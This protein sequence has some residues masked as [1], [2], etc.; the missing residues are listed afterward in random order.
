MPDDTA[1]PTAPCTV[2]DGAM[3]ALRALLRDASGLEIEDGRLDCAFLELGLDS[4]F[5]TQF[6]GRVADRFGVEVSFRRLATDLGSLRSLAAWIDAARGPSAPPEPSAPGPAPLAA[7]RIDGAL[8]EVLRGQLD[9]MRRQLKLIASPAA[10]LPT[11]PRQAAASAAPPAVP[12]AAAPSAP[13]TAQPAALDAAAP[14]VGGA[15][16]GR[17]ADGAPAWFV[18][19][20]TRP[21]RYRR[22]DA[23]SSLQPEATR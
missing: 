7:L 11:A 16:L 20:P 2:R 19:D 3:P 5:L 13:P 4:L 15:R 8:L 14:P 23:P 12:P 22:F 9:V 18:P 6:S 17:D 1:T 21:G 10:P